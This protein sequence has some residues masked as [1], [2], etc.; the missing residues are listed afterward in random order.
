MLVKFDL[1]EF[2]DQVLIHIIV[3]RLNLCVKYGEMIFTSFKKSK[4]GIIVATVI[5]LV[6]CNNEK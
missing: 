4:H 6:P 3:Y 5:V 1:C 2:P